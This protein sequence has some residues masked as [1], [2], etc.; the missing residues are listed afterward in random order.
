MDATQ[1]GLTLKRPIVIKVIVTPRWKE[2]VQQQ[3]QGQVGQLDGQLQQ[4]DQQAQKIVE[5]IKKQTITPIPP[6][7]AQQIDNIQIQANQKK[8]QILEQKN[9]ILQQLQQVQMLEMGQEAVQAQMEGYCSVAVGDNLIKKLNVQ[10][11]M[12][13]GIVEEIRGEL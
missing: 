13:D 9:Q 3:L 1:L 8:A 10:V 4:L 12:R 6:Q 11:V 7:V 5:D 2:E